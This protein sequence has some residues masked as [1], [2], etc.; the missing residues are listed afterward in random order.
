MESN[1]EGELRVPGK[2]WGLCGD[3][4]IAAAAVTVVRDPRECLLYITEAAGKYK[5]HGTLPSILLGANRL[6]RRSELYPG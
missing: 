3:R 5:G 4:V 2:D 1:R 6:S